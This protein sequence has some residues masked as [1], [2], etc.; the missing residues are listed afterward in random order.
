MFQCVNDSKRRKVVGAG[1]RYDSLI[2]ENRAGSNLNRH[3]VGFNLAWDMLVDSMMQ[4]VHPS[5]K[6]SQKKSEDD[7][8]RAAWK[9]RRCDVLVDSV[10]AGALR[11]SGINI[12]QELWANDISAE[13]VIDAPAR[14][15]ASYQNIQKDET[16]SYHWGVLI[17]QDETLK[18]RNIAR[19]ED[20]EIRR[21]ELVPWL[22]ADARDRERAG[23]SGGLTRP[24]H[25]GGSGGGGHEGSGTSDPRSS[26]VQILVAQHRS[27]KTNRRNI[28]DDALAR[29][30]SVNSTFGSAPIAAVELKDELFDAIRETR[31][32]DPESWRR[33]VQNAPLAERQYLSQVHGLLLEYAGAK[34][35]QGPRAVWLYNFRS[36]NCFLYD[37]GKDATK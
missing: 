35:G 10:D 3:G 33:C 24:G 30:A 28:V 16:A 15:L 12:V 13:L 32:A 29:T 19:R 8:V 20:T 4:F 27:K 11:S 37:L 9:P 23:A 17:K 31:L 6:Q 26:D 5:S 14:E 7:S 2:L 36:R 1:G 25:H 22:R 34:D 18:V 21:G